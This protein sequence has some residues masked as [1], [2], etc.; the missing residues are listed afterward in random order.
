MYRIDAQERVPEKM[1][2]I[3]PLMAYNE[4]LATEPREKGYILETE[5]SNWVFSLM[6]VPE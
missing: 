6:S 4:I 3:S 5:G 1:L 2:T